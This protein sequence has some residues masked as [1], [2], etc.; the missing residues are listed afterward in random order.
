MDKPSISCFFP[1]YN[2]RGTIATMV[3]AAIFTLRE[4]ASDYEVIVVDDGSTDGA[5]K[6]LTDLQTTFPDHLRLVFHDANRGYGG[7]LISGFEAATKDWIFY[8]DGDHQYDPDE[9]RL[10]VEQMSNDVDVV[11]GYKISR[12]DPYHRKVIGSIYQH[13]VRLF[14]GLTVRDVDCDFRLIRK[15]LMDRVTLTR[16]SGAI[17]VELMRKT[18]DAGA[19]YR[20]VG[21]RHFFRVY[22]RSQIFNVKRLVRS[23]AQLLGLWYELILR[24]RIGGGR[25]PSEP[26]T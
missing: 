19:R 25:S 6:L 13:T 12:N 10:L 22:G 5:R 24:P 7:A 9:L 8:T 2:D 15:S 23:V 16:R 21:V 11:Q 1:C 20:E 17:C 26:R 4:V 14:F 18:Q 3:C